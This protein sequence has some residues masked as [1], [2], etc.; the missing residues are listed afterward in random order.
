MNKKNPDLITSGLIIAAA[1]LLLQTVAGAILDTFGLSFIS[2]SLL[3]AQTVLTK[4]MIDF[5]LE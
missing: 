5:A 3:T 2:Y 1:L 4:V